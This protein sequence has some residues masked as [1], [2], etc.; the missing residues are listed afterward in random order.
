MT[1]H[2]KPHGLTPAE[3]GRQDAE[4]AFHGTPISNP[5]VTG[6]PEAHLWESGFDRATADLIESE[7]EAA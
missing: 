5:F 7:L 1:Q 3:L 4:A 6:S 2:L